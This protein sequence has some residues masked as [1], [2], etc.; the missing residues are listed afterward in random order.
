MIARPLFV[1]T[2]LAGSFLLFLVQPLVAR[3]ALPQLGGA[4]AVWNSAMLVYQALLLAGYAYAHAIARL[5]LKR[6]AAIHLAVLALAGLTLPIA[7]ADLAPPASQGLEALWVPLLF[8]LT[9]G[10]V[11]FA[12]SAQA[13][14]MQR[15]YAADPNAGDPY[16]LYAAS[17]LG[18]FA[19]LLAYPLFLEPNLPL[20]SQSWVWSIGYI[21]LIGLVA[22]AAWMRRG[23]PIV[24]DDA[25]ADSEA[26]PIGW[27]RIA[28]WLALAAVPS[29][30]MLSTTTHLTTDIVAMP[31][32]WV[33]P[34]GLYL[35]SF[36]FAF[37]ERSALGYTLARVAPVVVLLAGG[38]AM[39]S[40]N[41]ASLSIG[42]AT[43]LM[44]FVLATALHR[45]LY[46]ER[47][48]PRRLTLFYL[49]MSA[50]GALGGAFTALVAPLLFDWAWEHPILVLAGAALLPDRPLVAWMERLRLT[51]RQKKIAV[52]TLLIAAAIIAIL[53]NRWVIAQDNTLVLLGMLAV[54][55]CG[56]L[57][58]GHGRAMV[59]VLA[60]LMLGRGGY[61][62]LATSFE[63]SRD[64]SYFGIY[65]VRD[66]PEERKRSLVSGT[67]LHG[68][69]FTA[70]D[71]R[72]QPT[73]YY[74]PD[75]GVGA[76]L[77][78]LPAIAGPAARVG[79]VGLGVGTLACYRQP[80]QKWDFFEID[81]TVLSYSRDETFT[82]VSD[83]APDATI[84][85]GDARIMLDRYRETMGSDDRFDALVIDAF[86]SDA[87]PLHL[88][89][90]EA[91]GIYRRT[92]AEDGL[93]LVHI[94]N[95]FIDLTPMMAALAE[96]H[97]MIA[98]LRSHQDPPFADGISPSLWVVM[99]RDPAS[100]AKLLSARPDLSWHRLPPPAERVWTDD[101]ASIL[102][103]IQWQNVLGNGS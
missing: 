76:A 39:V 67:T 82:F 23:A 52:A 72:R 92:L 31:L 103:F 10:P 17:N 74:G 9:I 24:G 97:G 66:L 29:G 12:V 2:V 47:P 80:G 38:M 30:L 35:L 55:F 101:F 69:Q 49:V 40:Q 75:S 16:R 86:S 102:P 36:V 73:T 89:T 91:F 56:A 34:L 22:A 20:G 99:A 13:P 3:M 8:V 4:P 37:N 58:L 65:T 98:V 85:L 93:L 1:A 51:G 100:L 77:G 42:F 18:S 43:V 11:F 87:I 19:G 45:R 48:S 63:G 71:R 14:L 6:Q 53:V 90:D 25:I 84:H 62:T 41:A 59:L 88:V 96:R 21:L 50:G 5:P 81:R 83:C 94:S 46:F 78:E 95:R 7:L 57:L 26:E 33:I 15:W 44:L 28:L 54:A 32:L 61:Q 70:P 27:R 79:V 60:A 68:L 64:R